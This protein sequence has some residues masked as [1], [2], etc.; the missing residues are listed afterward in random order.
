MLHSFLEEDCCPHL[1]W[2]VALE[3]S[4]VKL[5]IWTQLKKIKSLHYKKVVKLFSRITVVLALPILFRKNHITGDKEM[6]NPCLFYLMSL[7]SILHRTHQ[8][9]EKHG[10]A[11]QKKWLQIS[12]HLKSEVVAHHGASFR[13]MSARTL[14]L[15]QFPIV[16]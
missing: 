1:V 15:F 11:F 14:G 7:E 9:T 5:L 4:Q 13:D 16:T 8:L 10:V 6:K 3:I 2:E 12:V